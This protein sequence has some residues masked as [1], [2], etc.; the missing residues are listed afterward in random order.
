MPS[1]DYYKILGVDKNASDSDIKSAYRNMAKKYHP[2]LNPNNTEAAEKF[3]ECNEAYEILSDKDKR[4]RYDRGEMDFDGNY[5]GF[6]PFGG[7]GGFGGFG[8][9]FDMFSDFMGGSGRRENVAQAGSDITYRLN[10][11]FLEA[12]KGCTKEISFSRMEKCHKCKGTGAKDEK[13]SKVCDKCKGTG[14]VQYVKNT[15]FGQ[16]VSV[17]Q[18][19]TCGGTGRIVT[20]KCKECKGTGLENKKK[21]ITVTIPAGVENGQVLTLRNEGNASKFANGING[22]VLIVVAVEPSNILSRENLDLFVE[23]PVSYSLAVRGGEIEVPTLNGK[24]IHKIPEGTKNN[25]VFRLRGMGI[26]SRRGIAGDLYVKVVI[27]VPKSVSKHEKEAILEF[28][29][30]LSM[31]NYPEQQKYN[32]EITKLYN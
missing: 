5:G 13:S 9:I 24:Y 1:K 8:D 18:C 14:R 28:E 23:V 2:D 27:E 16:S 25:E 32:E 11:T 10:L 20:D 12:C 30:K 21:V 31:K 22:N 3:K 15:I 7:G 26:K 19:N 29:R 17:G 4:A 6:N